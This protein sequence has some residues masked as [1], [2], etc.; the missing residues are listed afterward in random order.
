[1]SD[2]LSWNNINYIYI[3]MYK[4]LYVY[5][6][7]IFINILCSKSKSHYLELLYTNS[8]RKKWKKQQ[9][10]LVGT[11]LSV[12]LDLQ[13]L[14]MAHNCLIPSSCRFVP[15][16]FSGKLCREPAVTAVTSSPSTSL[17]EKNC[18]GC[19]ADTS[20]SSFGSSVKVG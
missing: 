13:S 5:I 4:I 18:K 9:T 1:M 3:C 12:T 8:V 7:I 15:A 11:E 2:L 10:A 17:M 6:Y 16:S 14:I 19:F 20:S